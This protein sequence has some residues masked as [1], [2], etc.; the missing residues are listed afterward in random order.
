MK[1]I[2]LAVMFASLIAVVSFN[3]GAASTIPASGVTYTNGSTSTTVKDSLDDLISKAKVGTA[4]ASQI[5]SGKTALVQGS[6]VT[7]TMTDRGAVNQTLSAGGSYTIP[8]GYH[9]GSG[10]VT[11]KSLADQTSA[12]ASAFHILSGY[13]AYVNGTKLTGTIV[14]NKAVSQTLSAGGSYTIPAGYHNGSGKVTATSLADQTSATATAADIL[15]GKTAY[16]NGSQ[17]TGTNDGGYRVYTLSTKKA[18]ITSDGTLNTFKNGTWTGIAKKGTTTTFSVD[19]GFTPSSVVAC[20][21]ALKGNYVSSSTTDSDEDFRAARGYS[22]A[23][24]EGK[25]QYWYTEDLRASLTN[26]GACTSATTSNYGCY[27]LKCSI[28]GS[29]VNLEVKNIYDGTS[30]GA[31]IATRAD[32]F[33]LSGTIVYK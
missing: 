31:A 13:T 29:K 24:S 14:D 30:G 28:S 5:L 2:V 18:T 11:A 21:V 32:V 25:A 9:N 3:V 20:D 10:K 22:A 6:T 1:K 12:T 23:S 8:A 17:I 4:S 33:Y 19:L 7:G 27:D 26:V 15:S 16:V